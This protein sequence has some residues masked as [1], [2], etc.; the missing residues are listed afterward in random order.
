[1]E[2]IRDSL[3]GALL[4]LIIWDLFLSD[5]CSR[6]RHNPWLNSKISYFYKKTGR[7]FFHKLFRI[8]KMKG[9]GRSP[10]CRE[11]VDSYWQSNFESR[12]LNKISINVQDHKRVF[13]GVCRIEV[14]PKGYDSFKYTLNITILD[15]N[16][17]DKKSISLDINRKDKKRLAKRMYGIFVLYHKKW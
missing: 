4:A 7:D 14:E 12:P 1:M 11:F 15:S 13:E 5:V 8:N 10:S 2:I 9:R 17:V 3:I 6:I 16:G